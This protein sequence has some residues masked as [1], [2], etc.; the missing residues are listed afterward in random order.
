MKPLVFLSFHVI[1]STVEK[2]SPRGI[3][4][5]FQVTHTTLKGTGNLVR[6]TKRTKDSVLH[7]Q[8]CYRLNDTGLRSDI[9]GST[10]RF[11][12]AIACWGEYIGTRP[13]ISAINQAIDRWLRLH[14]FNF[15]KMVALHIVLNLEIKIWFL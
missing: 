8:G 10:S 3:H 2:L 6:I 11:E 13:H 7:D 9:C 14:E 4:Q 1:F 5:A 15:E 12:W